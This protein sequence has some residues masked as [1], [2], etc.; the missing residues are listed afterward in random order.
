MFIRIASALLLACLF[1]AGGICA[2]VGFW[3][4][5]QKVEVMVVVLDEA[6][7]S[8]IGG[9]EIWL[10]A[11]RE[12]EIYHLGKTNPRGL[13][14]PLETLGNRAESRS[15]G[16][17][18]LKTRFEA[19]G[20]IQYIDGKRVDTGF[21]QASGHIEVRSSGYQDYVAEIAALVP[22]RQRDIRE[23]YLRLTVKLKRTASDPAH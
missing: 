22:E 2:D 18:K 12:G 20:S 6:D 8:P 9:A 11:G 16:T 15:D 10:L 7:N 13:T 5:E 14:R 1:T 3:D 19:G 4:G 17:L 23:P 21:W